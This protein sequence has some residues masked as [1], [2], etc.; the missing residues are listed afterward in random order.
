MSAPFMS[1]T[2]FVKWWFSWSST[3]KI[4]FREERDPRCEHPK[5]LACDGT[6]VGL[7][8]SKL[9]LKG[10][11]TPAEDS[12]DILPHHKRY[13]RVFFALPGRYRQPSG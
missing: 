11:D 10:V 7:S 1:N 8:L 4:D 13:N 3:M 12:V 6:H 9:S 5:F 2:T